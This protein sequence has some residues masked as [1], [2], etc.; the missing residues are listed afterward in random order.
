MI[1]TET[2]GLV[3]DAIEKMLSGAIGVLRTGSVQPKV[4][5]VGHLAFAGDGDD[6]ARHLAGVDLSLQS[7][8]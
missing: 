7:G 5:Q 6:G 1:A 8:R 2:I 3:I 4:S